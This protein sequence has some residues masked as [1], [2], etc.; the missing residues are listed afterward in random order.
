[1]TNPNNNVAEINKNL[2]IYEIYPDGYSSF[3]EYDDDGITQAYLNGEGVTTQIEAEVGNKNN[4]TV[5][6]QPSTGDFKGFVKE[7][8][9][10]KRIQKP[11]R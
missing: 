3:T 11:I 10:Q 4:V 1:M 6:I 5:T 2:R 9:L 7:K 8:A